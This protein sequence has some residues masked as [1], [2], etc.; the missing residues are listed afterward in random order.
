M[1]YCVGGLQEMLD[2][3]QGKNFPEWQAHGYMCQLMDGLEYL[4]SQGTIHKDIKPSNL[5]LTTGGILKI[6]DFGV[7]E[8]LDY[9]AKDDTCRTSQ[10]SPAFQPPEIANGL[11]S[12]SGYKVDVWSSGITLFNIT[13]GK[14]PFEGDNIY[15]LFENIGTGVFT[16]PKDIPSLL[17]SLLAGMLKMDPD[18]RLGVQEIKRHPWIVGKPKNTGNAVPLPPL[19]ESSDELR[20]MTVIPYLDAMYNPVES[21]DE[22]QF[23]R[24]SG[25]EGLEGM[26]R[27]EMQVETQVQIIEE[28]APPIDALH[29]D[30]MDEQNVQSHLQVERPIFGLG[31]DMVRNRKMSRLRRMSPANCKQQ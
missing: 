24:R 9:F 10:G 11:D 30:D 5:L 26:T 15:R 8:R 19:P 21:D 7:A 4:H 6:S 22:N 17:A 23:E 16:M 18:D 29:D 2:T 3:A 28:H 13:T 1:E 25:E 12:F 27:V 14:F 20:S 31:D